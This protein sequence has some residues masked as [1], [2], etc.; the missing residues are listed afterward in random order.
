MLPYKLELLQCFSACWLICCHLY[1]LS[2]SKCSFSFLFQNIAI[3]SNKTLDWFSNSF[4]EY[5]A[6]RNGVI[7]EKE[8]CHMA[9]LSVFCL[10]TCTERPDI[11]TVES[12]VSPGQCQTSYLFMN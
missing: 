9:L 8:I 3:L 10:E 12:M 11:L 5:F 6:N 2:V 1:V 7:P 4:H